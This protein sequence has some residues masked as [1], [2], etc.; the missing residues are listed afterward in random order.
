MRFAATSRLHANRRLIMRTRILIAVAGAVL[1]GALI[2][3]PVAAS[4]LNAPALSPDH[5]PPGSVIH[6]TGFPAATSCPSVR[7]YIA[8]VAGVTSFSDPRLQRLTGRVTYGLGLGGAS[9]G[10]LVGVPL[11]RF[12]AP[13]LEPGV[14]TTYFTCVGSTNGWNALFGD[15]ALRV[16][17]LAPGATLPPTTTVST[18]IPSSEEIAPAVWLLI[19][20]LSIAAA[21]AAGRRAAH[22]ARGGE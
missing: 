6:V 16:E 11:L 18:A 3:G 20:L 15:N 5:G 7:M 14:Y 19:G 9:I 8:P 17:P 21:S 10:P 22:E 4:L 1:G 13:A 12:T 2:A